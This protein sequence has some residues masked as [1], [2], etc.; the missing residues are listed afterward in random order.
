MQVELCTFG[1][2]YRQQI[3][4]SSPLKTL[5]IDDLSVSMKKPL[6]KGMWHELTYPYPTSLMRSFLAN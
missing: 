6:F 2:N 5:V 4:P 3:L 1:F